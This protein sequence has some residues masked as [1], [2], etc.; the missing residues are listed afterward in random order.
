[1]HH[2]IP[3][4]ASMAKT[5]MEDEEGPASYRLVR[6]SQ[7]PWTPFHDLRACRSLPPLKG[8][9]PFLPSSV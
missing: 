4:G 5:A 7:F 1:V 3:G 6:K 9:P 8:A 2:H